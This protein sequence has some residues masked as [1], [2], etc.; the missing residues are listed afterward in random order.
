MARIRSLKP[1]FWTSEQLAEC[2]RDARLLFV[3]LWTFSD[4]NG[5]HKAKPKRLKMEVFP[6]DSDC[7]EEQM[8]VWI[9]ELI[10]NG[11]VIEYTV[12]GVDYWKV[13]GWKKHQRIDQPTFRYPLP[14]GAVPNTP[15]RRRQ[16]PKV[17]DERSTNTS[18][19]STS[20]RQGSGVERK[21]S[22]KE[23]AV[24]PHV[25]ADAPTPISPKSK[26]KKPVAQSKAAPM[27]YPKWFETELWPLYPKREGSN[28]KRAAFHAANAR[29]KEGHT[30]KEMKTGTSRYVAYLKIKG[31]VGTSLTMTAKRFFGTNKEF[32]EEWKLPTEVIGAG[33]NGIN[34]RTTALSRVG[35]ND[36]ESWA[37]V[38][39]FPKSNSHYHHSYVEYRKFLQRCIVEDDRGN[40]VPQY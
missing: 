11:L 27:V 14:E 21:G 25:D 26:E 8:L 40:P 30:V 6:A 20:V 19:R 9:D 3:G 18:K 31:H 15:T 35:D 22:G 7:S 33:G 10:D 17:F 2:C 4:D 37:V 38:Q 32:T 39:G 36:L 23:R 28:P 29:K 13:T 24:M 34:K 12:D 5:I 16:T 1:E